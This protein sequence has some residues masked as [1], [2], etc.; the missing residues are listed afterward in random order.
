M[1]DWLKKIRDDFRVYLERAHPAFL[2]TLVVL[3]YYCPTNIFSRDKRYFKT[4]YFRRQQLMVVRWP[5]PRPFT[6]TNWS[7][8]RST[9]TRTFTWLRRGSSRLMVKSWGSFTLCHVIKKLNQLEFTKELMA[10]GSK[11]STS[12]E[13]ALP[14]FIVTYFQ[15]MFCL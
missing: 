9:P 5:Q 4:K 3:V 10:E 11:L 7:R 8:T 14:N 6:A 13:S 15:T 2:N 12:C 1:I